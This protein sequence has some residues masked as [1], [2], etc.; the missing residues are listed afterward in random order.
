MSWIRIGFLSFKDD[1]DL[2]RTAGL[3][4]PCLSQ[5]KQHPWRIDQML[6]QGQRGIRRVHL[7]TYAHR[8][9][10]RS[11]FAYPEFSRAKM[12]EQKAEAA[13]TWRLGGTDDH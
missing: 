3:P 4:P 1:R 8:S 10:R 13:R 5:A 11:G 6:R 7:Y 9:G 12:L 2:C